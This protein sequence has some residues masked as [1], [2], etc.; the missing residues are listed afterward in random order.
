MRRVGVVAA[1][2][3]VA[4]SALVCPAVD[5]AWSQAKFEDSISGFEPDDNFPDGLPPYVPLRERNALP[6]FKWVFSQSGWT[7]NQLIEALALAVTNNLSDEVLNSME[8]RRIPGN[9]IWKLSEIN[10]PAVTNFF[11]ALNEIGN[12]RLGP[13]PMSAPFLYTNLE[14][15]VLAYMRSLC[16]KTNIYE[17]AVDGVLFNM[18]ETMDTM[19]LEL[20]PAATNRVAKFIYY[21]V[22][23]TTRQ[24]VYQDKRLAGLV[25]AYSN[26]IQRLGAMRYVAATAT[27][28]W[29]R[30]HAQMEAN[31]L[32]A[33][34]VGQLNDLPWIV[35]ED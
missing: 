24:M 23:H 27:N 15:E 32:S 2:L 35:E 29:Q 18:L 33:L 31:R 30:V 8:K 22:R 25:P 19:P 11:R 13:T 5:P 9:A 20:K 34:P 28:Q 7:T 17:R 4:G 6:E 21:S 12:P 26:S 10:H 1:L 16:L 3:A 14:P